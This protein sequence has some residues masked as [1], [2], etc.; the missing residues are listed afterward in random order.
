MTKLTRREWLAK[1]VTTGAG[2]VLSGSLPLLNPTPCMAQRGG[3]AQF[4][5]TISSYNPAIAWYR[6]RCQRCGACYDFCSRFMTVSGH[7]P[8]NGS[9]GETPCIQCGQCSIACKPNAITE[10]YDFPKVKSQID[11]SEK[12]VIATTSPAVRVALGECFGLLQG[13]DFEGKMVAAL[14]AVGFDY[15]LDTTFAADLTVS[16]ETAELVRR[17]TSGEKHDMPLFTSCCP[18]WVS[19]AEIFY[20]EILPNLSS[21][22]SPILMQGAMIKTYFAKQQGIDPERIV[23][24]AIA[25]CTAK[26]FEITRPE[27]NAS[28]RFHKKEHIRDMDYVLTTRELAYM[29]RGTKKP[30]ESLP[31]EKFDS[32]MGR[33]SGAGMIFGNTGGVTEA[34]LRE[35]WVLL[36]GKRPP[37]KLYKLESARGLQGV[38]EASLD[39][40]G[41]TVRIAIVHGTGYARG[42]IDAIKKGKAQYDFVE[43]MACPGGCVGG[44]GQPKSSGRYHLSRTILEQRING[45]YKKDEAQKI[46]LSSDNPEIKAIYRDFLGEPLG[47]KSESLLH[48]TYAARYPRKA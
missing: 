40:D 36:T 27:M 5:V 38:R 28:G 32:L 11:N 15:V 41:R 29:F 44:G 35:A 25:P 1:S 20:P 47:P 37:D 4:P 46:R 43:V 3:G 13:G 16:E 22:K 14:R 34:A 19:F 39:I 42:L 31:E 45:L 26:K 24:V 12:V 2:V 21:S 23:N 9:N 7:T 8:P 18:A 33:G 30:F 6:Q 17:I 48:T 10:R